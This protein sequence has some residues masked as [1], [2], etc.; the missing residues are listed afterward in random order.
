MSGGP[1]GGE[2]EFDSG[3]ILKEE[4]AGFFF[5][6]MRK[7][8]GNT[9][10]SSRIAPRSWGSTLRWAALAEHVQECGGG[11]SSWARLPFRGP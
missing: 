8:E 9:K 7:R 1:G 11:G 5:S 6:L 2:K 10:I 4:L 3:R